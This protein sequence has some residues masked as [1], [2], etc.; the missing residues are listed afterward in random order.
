MNGA[1]LARRIRQIRP[2]MPLL[3][4]TGYSGPAEEASTLPRLDKPFRRA[5]LAA[6][7]Q[8]V[9]SPQSNVVALRQA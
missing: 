4:I 2:D 5:E 8:R 9:V 6:A 3:L 1:E 7:I